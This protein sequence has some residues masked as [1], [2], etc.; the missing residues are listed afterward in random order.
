[1]AKMTVPASKDVNV[2]AMLMMRASLLV[3]WRNLLN[4]A[5]VVREPKPML[6]LKKD[7]VTAAYHTFSSNNF[8]HF[9]V[10]K[11]KT[12]LIRNEQA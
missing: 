6:R 1:M 10:M 3:G 5:L 4:E 12:P 9:G 11:R 8:S 2:S 7:W